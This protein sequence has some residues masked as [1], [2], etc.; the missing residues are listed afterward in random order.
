M[1]LELCDICERNTFK[2]DFC[3]YLCFDLSM[4]GDIFVD[5]FII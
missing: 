4:E 5:E 1:K 3:C 2:D